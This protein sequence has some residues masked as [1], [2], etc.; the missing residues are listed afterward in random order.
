MY[1][2]YGKYNIARLEEIDDG[3]DVR[4]KMEFL[5]VLNHIIQILNIE[6]LIIVSHSIEAD[7]S[8]VD[9]IKL[10][11]YQDFEDVM[12]TGNIIYDYSEEIKK[13]IS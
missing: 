12:S 7:T 4:N 5:N 8:N 9:I 10:K 11:T 3:L 1:D 13:T 2:V 6:Q